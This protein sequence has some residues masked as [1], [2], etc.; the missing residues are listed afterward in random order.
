MKGRLYLIPSLLDETAP[1][2]ILPGEIISRVRKIRYFIVENERTARR[3]L[4]SLGMKELLGDVTFELLN[5]YT[6]PEELEGML[7]PLNKGLSIGLISEA[8]C[9]GV[10]D[11]G[12]DIVAIAHRN[13]IKVVPLVGPSSILLALMG[14]GLN[15]QQFTFNGYLP[16]KSPARIRKIKQLEEISRKNHTTQIFIEAPYRNHQLF[17]DLLSTL[18]S[19]TRLCL[20]INL[21]GP[22]EKIL[23]KTVNEWKKVK[24]EFQK[25][26][27]VFLFLG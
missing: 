21:T 4:I 7:L 17:S 2:A 14:S 16:V 20:A 25:R 13:N 15:G 6:K 24:I 23:T 1:G 5:K 10:A 27:A 19:A 8:G 12:A 11:P 26:P 3:F 22:D 18:N 9:P